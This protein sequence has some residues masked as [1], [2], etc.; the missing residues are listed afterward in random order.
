MTF[1][2]FDTKSFSVY[3]SVTK[4]ISLKVQT[5]MSVTIEDI[6]Q[7]LGIAVS[8]VSKALNDYADVSQETKDR[9]LAAASQLDYHPS[10][11]ARN[12]RRRRTDKIGFSFSFPVSLMSDYISRLITGAVAAAEQ[13]GFNLILYPLLVDQVKQLTQICRAR[14]VDGLLLLGR[15]HMEQ[16]TIA[17]LKQ[18]D[19]PFV[20][21]GRRVESPEVSYV[22]P[23]HAAG[24]LAI[25]RHLIDLGHR[26]IA[27]TTRP[28]LG[29]TSRDRL[30]SYKQALIEAGIAYD[31]SLV[32]PTSTEPGHD[33]AA[34][35]SL[36]D[37]PHPPTAVFAIHD[38]V[39]LECLRAAADRGLQVPED[40]AIAGF[41]DWR[42]S[43]TSQP[44]LTTVHPPLPEIGLRAT[45]ILLA[46]VA[47]PNLPP[48][49]VTLPV[50]LV[51]R[52]STVG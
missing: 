44:P 8:T 16:T 42:A 33:Y 21:V 32:V 7:Q 38:T 13:Q 19:I 25:T 23:D 6:A 46:H 48:E 3:Y 43:L 4:T 24:A 45:E 20:V 27:F 22:T 49:R 47:D 40:V 39:A 5:Q 41:D 29:I 28:E 9:V 50:E 15:A 14:E 37:L 30:A 52:Q 11:A 51:I 36:L 12:L 26:R 2:T 35:N 10:A 18:E 34:M 31:E 17:L 1:I